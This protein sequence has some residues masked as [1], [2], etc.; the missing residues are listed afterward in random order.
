MSLPVFKHVD[1]TF[2]HERKLSNYLFTPFMIEGRVW[3]GSMQ[4]FSVANRWGLVLKR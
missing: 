1:D 4:N 2:I 3:F